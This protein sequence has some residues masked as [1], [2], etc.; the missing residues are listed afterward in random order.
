VIM[1]NRFLKLSVVGFAAV[2]AVGLAIF[3]LRGADSGAPSGSTCEVVD[4]FAHDPNAF[5]QGLVFE[6]GF[7]Y[8]GT[9]LNGQSELRKVELETGDVLP[10]IHLSHRGLGPDP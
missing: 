6:D 1:V 8:E 7:L 10:G 5:T 4:T 9:G 2:L 3:A